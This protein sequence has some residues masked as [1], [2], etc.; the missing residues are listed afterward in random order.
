[1]KAVFV[2]K[3]NRTL[4]ELLKNPV[5]VEGETDWLSILSSTFGK[6]KNRKHSTIKMNPVEGSKKKNESKF[7]K[8]KI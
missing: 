4:R 1:M 6:Y 3:F 5:F 8:L 2:E 7:H